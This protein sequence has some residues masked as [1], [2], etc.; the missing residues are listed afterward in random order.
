[1]HRSYQWTAS[2]EILHSIT[3]QLMTL[4]VLI[5]KM[6]GVFLY[7]QL[8]NLY[9]NTWGLICFQGK[10]VCKQKQL[11]VNRSCLRIYASAHDIINVHQPNIMISY[12][13]CWALAANVCHETI[14]THAGVQSVFVLLGTP[15]VLGDSPSQTVISVRIACQR[16]C[17]AAATNEYKPAGEMVSWICQLMMRM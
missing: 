10:H 16:C 4:Q 8:C 12:S 7:I 11:Q 3:V 13:I 14:P 5:C 2:V 17:C 9:A 6:T 15:Y 1:M